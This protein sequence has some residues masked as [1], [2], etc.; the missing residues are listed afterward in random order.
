MKETYNWYAQILKP[1]WS[2]PSW[3]FG[4]VW[5]TLFILIGVSLFIVWKKNWQVQNQLL[6]VQKKSWNPWTKRFWSG[7]WQKE[8][9]IVI[10]SVQLVLNVGDGE[11]L[12]L[13]VEPLFI[14]FLFVLLMA[15]ARSLESVSMKKVV[16]T[17][18]LREG[19]W[20]FYDIKIG[21]K[22]FKKDWSGLSSEKIE[23]LKP[24]KKEK[25]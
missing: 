2:P 22:E 19:D 14:L 16:L 1:T 18:D 17:K 12:K 10:F 5:T 8:N 13:L 20:L 24:K 23:F 15:F 6:A 9:I 3:V 4:P 7:D 11:Q 25:K 21:G